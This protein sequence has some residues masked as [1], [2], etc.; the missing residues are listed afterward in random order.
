MPNDLGLN[1]Y[2]YRCYDH[3]EIVQ[4]WKY[5]DMGS[6]GHGECRNIRKLTFPEF[7]QQLEQDF[8]DCSFEAQPLSSWQ[9]TRV[10]NLRFIHDLIKRYG[11]KDGFEI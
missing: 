7:I 9:K 3:N 2:Y 6:A 1:K 4:Y 8:M 10:D 11:V 5:N